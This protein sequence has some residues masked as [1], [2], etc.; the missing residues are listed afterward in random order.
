MPWKQVEIDFENPILRQML[1][2]HFPAQD[3]VILRQ[4]GGATPGQCYTNVRNTVSRHGGEAVLCYV[5]SWW[6]GLFIEALHHAIWKSPSGDLID[7]TAP[8]YPAIRQGTAT[9]AVLLPEELQIL[10]PMVPSIFWAISKS[11]IVSQYIDASIDAS[12]AKDRLNKAAQRFAVDAASMAEIK[13]HQTRVQAA[14]TQRAKAI[15]GM[16]EKFGRKSWQN[17]TELCRP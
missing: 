5:F 15:A 16:E 17:A 2:R 11:R 3:P 8:A 7:I 9:L 12:I 4:H 14:C 13:R 6:P 10:D 1:D